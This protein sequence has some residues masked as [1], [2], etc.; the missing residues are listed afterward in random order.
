MIVFLLIPLANPM[1][2]NHSQV[3]RENH[4]IWNSRRPYISLIKQFNQ[5]YIWLKSIQWAG[6][7]RISFWA[8][9]VADTVSSDF[10][11]YYSLSEII[12]IVV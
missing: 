12:S 8:I 6:R 2:F 7:K 11:L 1:P 3:L 9:I 4:M 10:Y 5:L